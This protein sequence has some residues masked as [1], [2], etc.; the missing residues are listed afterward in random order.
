[1]IKLIVLLLFMHLKVLFARR[2]Q[3]IMYVILLLLVTV[4]GVLSLDFMIPTLVKNISRNV[5]IHGVIQNWMDMI[6]LSSIL[7]RK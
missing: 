5:L 2:I 7:I 6:F 3:L 1:M 4:F